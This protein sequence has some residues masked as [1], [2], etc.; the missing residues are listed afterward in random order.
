[1]IKYLLLLLPLLVFSNQIKVEHSIMKPLGK[2]VQTNAQITQLSDQKQEIV[3]RLSGHVEAYYVK[4][5]EHVKSGDKVVLIESIILSKLTADYLA[6]V[7]QIKPA[8]S[9]VNTTR[10][11]YKK[12]LASKNQL[13][14]HLIALETLR[15]Q[16]NALASQLQTLGLHPSK[17]TKATD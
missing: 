14:A 12:G 17:L 15:S 6:L 10:I 5:G 13:S 4:A 16:K 9:Q 8:K 1:M 2:M 7:Q 3:S 11:L